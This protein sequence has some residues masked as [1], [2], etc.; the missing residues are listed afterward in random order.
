MKAN[1]HLY[2]AR[3]IDVEDLIAMHE[4]IQ[5]E[6][7]ILKWPGLVGS[8][9]HYA[10][11][12]GK[13]AAMQLLVDA[14]MPVDT[15]DSDGRCSF[16][17]ES[18]V[19]ENQIESVRW[20]LSRGANPNRGAL[21]AAVTADAR[22]IIEL[23]LASGADP[24]MRTGNP[25]RSAYEQAVRLGNIEM[26]SLLAPKDPGFD[27]LHYLTNQYG[28]LVSIDL[29]KLP[30]NAPFSVKCFENNKARIITTFGLSFYDQPALPYRCELAIRVPKT[31]PA[32][33]LLGPDLFWPYEYLL[34]VAASS[35]QAPILQIFHTVGNGEPP[36]P[37]GIEVLFYGAMIVPENYEAMPHDALGNP[38][39]L[40]SLQPLFKE[41]LALAR[42]NMEKFVVKMDRSGFDPKSLMNLNRKNVGTSLFGF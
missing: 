38:V 14:G 37:L 28:D 33:R 34:D 17:L 23:L 24:N 12:N 1:K 39:K 4:M 3:L 26:Q 35:L 18:A 13:I 31:W 27:L 25:S 2:L 16:P 21:V 29:P 8:W 22:A 10:A 5:T 42:K 36:Q 7:G 19:S 32:A 6:E 11:Q 41:E 40:F 15:M 9:L 20:L 30:L